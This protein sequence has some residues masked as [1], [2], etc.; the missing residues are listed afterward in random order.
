MWKLP[1]V[2][3]ALAAS[4][5]ALR[6]DEPVVAEQVVEIN[7]LE[8][9]NSEPVSLESERRQALIEQ[10]ILSG[11]VPDWAGEYYSGDG[12]GKN[13]T[14][15]LAPQGGFTYHWSGCLGIYDRNYGT[16]T[17]TEDG[18]ELNL[19]LANDEDYFGMARHFT[20][21]RWGDRHYL[22]ASGEMMAFVN[23]V[24]SGN[25]PC[26]QWCSSFLMR[27]GDKDRPVSGQPE[28]PDEYREMLLFHAIAAR[29]VRIVDSE[30]ILDDEGTSGWRTTTVELDVGADDGVVEGM[31]LYAQQN[32]YPG[33]GFSVV[34]TDAHHATA[35]LREMVE[36]NEPLP[37]PGLCLSTR[38]REQTCPADQTAALR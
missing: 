15:M 37:E 36:L 23:A 16:V 30:T 29:V 1:A 7:L 35:E 31:E 17:A 4:S 27:E 33:S 26:S 22:L 5:L 2:V 24:N 12:L 20:P 13:V 3:L 10:E 9:K 32:T 28:L 25:E 18:I 21:V 11:A 19:E 38:P 8:F 34:S 6:A 14:L